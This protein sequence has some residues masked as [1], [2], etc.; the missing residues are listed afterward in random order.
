VSSEEIQSILR[1]LHHA[2]K[3]AISGTPENRS[4]IDE[5]LMR[6]FMLEFQNTDLDGVT[7]VVPS[8][9]APGIW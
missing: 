2:W 3:G 9:T 7:A 8:L 1:F 5:L 4:R 6:N